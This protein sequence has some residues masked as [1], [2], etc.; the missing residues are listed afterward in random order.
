MFKDASEDRFLVGINSVAG[1]LEAM[2]LVLPSVNSLI[3]RSN[4]LYLDAGCGLLAGT[5][6]FSLK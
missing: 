3:S 2:Y 5:L 4:S 1:L 6:T